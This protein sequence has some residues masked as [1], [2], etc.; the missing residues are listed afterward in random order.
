ML[1]FIEAVCFTFQIRNYVNGDLKY[2]NGRLSYDNNDRDYMEWVF[3]PGISGIKDFVVN[4]F[5]NFIAILEILKNLTI[6]FNKRFSRMVQTGE[7]GQ[8]I[9]VPKKMPRKD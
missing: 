6:S 9:C 5:E 1:H 4:C 2:I 8:G 7:H 3:I